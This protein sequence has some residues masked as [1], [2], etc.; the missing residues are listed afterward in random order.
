M[1]RE[2]VAASVRHRRENPEM[3]YWHRI[4][5]AYGLSREQFE[6]MLASQ[7]GVCAIC[8]TDTPGGRSG[9]WVV[10]HDHQ[11]CPGTRSCGICVR[12]LLCNACNHGLGHFADRAEVLRRAAAY[13]EIPHD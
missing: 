6:K 12:G 4:K 11:C 2:K 8:R 13:V 7:G 9:K 5:Y 3:Y 10:D 1:K